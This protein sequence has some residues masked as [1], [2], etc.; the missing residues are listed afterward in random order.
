LRRPRP[1]HQHTV[2]RKVPGTRATTH[3]GLF[4]YSKSKRGVEF[5]KREISAEATIL[6]RGALCDVQSADKMKEM[7][8]TLERLNKCKDPVRSPLLN[9]SWEL[10]YTD[11]RSILG[12]ERPSFLRPIGTIRQAIDTNRLLAKNEERIQPLPFLGWDNKVYATLRAESRSRVA[13]RFRKFL[14]GNL[15]TL[16]APPTACG[17]L[18]TTYLDET[19]RISRGDKGSIFCLVREFDDDFCEEGLRKVEATLGYN[20]I[21]S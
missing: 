8:E 4:G 12:T 3:A 7:I 2:G 13:V 6:E 10:I 17:W 21:I 19:F 5:L 15:V 18:E 20:G 1:S 11:S 14:I 9:G 16:D